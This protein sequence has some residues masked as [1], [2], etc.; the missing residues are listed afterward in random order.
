MPPERQ[1]ATLRR[2]ALDRRPSNCR[3]ERAALRWAEVHLA[4]ARDVAEDPDGRVTV[5]VS[6]DW[7]RWYLRDLYAA[8]T[9]RR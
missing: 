6:R 2:L 1:L 9:R 3:C 4:Q 7:H 5:A 8:A